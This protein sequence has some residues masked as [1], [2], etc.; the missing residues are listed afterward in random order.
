[1][2]SANVVSLP[3]TDTISSAWKKVSGI[4]GAIW[5]AYGLM[6]IIIIGFA[7]LAWIAKTLFPDTTADIFI[8]D[9]AGIIITLMLFGVMYIAIQ[10]SEDKPVSHT[11]VYYAFSWHVIWRLISAQLMCLVLLLPFVLAGFAAPFYLAYVDHYLTLHP[12]QTSMPQA[13]LMLWLLKA[14]YVIAGFITFYLAVRMML[15]I[16]FLLDNTDMGP[17]QAIRSSFAATR[18]NFWRIIVF[19]ILSEILYTL[20]SLTVIGLIWGVPFVYTS[21]AMLYQTLKVNA[22]E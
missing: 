17:L 10:H 13:T 8:W 1:M 11:M 5:G 22:V 14:C 2:S 16:F 7:V 3:I 21:Y 19:F 12:L 6:L 4:K 15:T 20:L 18:R 9:A